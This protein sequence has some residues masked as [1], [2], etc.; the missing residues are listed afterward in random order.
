M[1]VPNQQPSKQEVSVV[2]EMCRQ[3]ASSH[4]NLDHW[5]RC[6]NTAAGIHSLYLQTD[7]DRYRMICRTVHRQTDRQTDRQIYVIKT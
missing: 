4:Q 2:T 3:L 1:L 6:R 5:K 7:R